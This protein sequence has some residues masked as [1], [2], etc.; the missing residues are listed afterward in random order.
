MAAVLMFSSEK[1]TEEVPG[2]IGL[3][4]SRYR[5]VSMAGGVGLLGGL[6][7]QGGSFIL[8]P[9]MTSFLKISFLTISSST[10]KSSSRLTLSL[11]K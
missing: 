6:V 4:F 8:I 3:E 7:G 2:A 11:L 5:A 10:L 9:L 1:V